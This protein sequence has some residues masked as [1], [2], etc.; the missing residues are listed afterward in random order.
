MV[1]GVACRRAAFIL[2]LIAMAMTLAQG[3]SAARVE[4]TLLGVFPG[5]DSAAQLATDLGVPSGDV[6]L[7]AKVDLPGA[8]PSDPSSNDGLTLSNFTLNGDNEAISGW[9]DY[10]GVGTVTV[11]VVKA[12]NQYAAYEYTPA[13]TGGMMNM[14]LWDTSD[15]GNKGVSHV[16]AY[17]VIPEPASAL[18]VGLGL[19]GLAARSKR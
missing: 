18:L 6:T 8:S 4:G 10:T 14:G 13:L 5:N 11:L 17:S 12:G 2:W 19:L 16:S 9:W 15:L 1:R 7:L 3:A